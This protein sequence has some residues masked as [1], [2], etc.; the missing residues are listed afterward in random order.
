LLVELALRFLRLSVCI[1]SRLKD[2][3]WD[4]H[5]SQAAGARS[6]AL[7]RGLRRRWALSR[8]AQERSISCLP[9][10]LPACLPVCLPANAV[11]QTR[12]PNTQLL[13]TLRI[14]R[15]SCYS[16][17][18]RQSINIKRRIYIHLHLNPGD[19]RCFSILNSH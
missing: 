2:G 18:R 11:L 1:T 7:V 17:I 13:M 10:C 8:S 15:C 12:G 4:T 6:G 5:T 3:Q 19:C 14:T 16:R 9:A